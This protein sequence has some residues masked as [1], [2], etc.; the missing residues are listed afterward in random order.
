MT[1]TAQPNPTAALRIRNTVKRSHLDQAAVLQILCDYW[2]CA[3]IKYESNG[4]EYLV[5]NSATPV[6]AL[7]P[8]LEEKP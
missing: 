6:I 3:W 5:G 1:R 2:G 8:I 4:N 7:K